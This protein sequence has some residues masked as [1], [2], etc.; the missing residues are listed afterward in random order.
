MVTSSELGL[1]GAI[2]SEA[3]GAVAGALFVS[4]WEPGIARDRWM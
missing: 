3:S 1:D 2:P 4:V